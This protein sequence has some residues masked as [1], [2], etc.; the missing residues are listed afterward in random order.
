[1]NSSQPRVLV[2]DDERLLRKSIKRILEKTGFYVETALDYESAKKC[3]K[4]LNFDLLLVDIILP[5]INGIELI[6]KLQ[7]DF[8]DFNSAIIFITGEPNLDTSRK[9]IRLGAYDYLEKPVERTK[10]IDA[11]KRVLKRRKYRLKVEDNT[12]DTTFELDDSFFE[13]TQNEKIK[14]L[15]QKTKKQI[16]E[17]YDALYK[18]KKKYGDSFNEEQKKLLNVIAE[19]NNQMRKEWNSNS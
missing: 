1:M 7:K 8:E 5:Q 18:L 11:I 13:D 4:N 15:K 16:K 10:L 12:R 9:A 14:E 2:I 19:N 17:I 6:E 3:L